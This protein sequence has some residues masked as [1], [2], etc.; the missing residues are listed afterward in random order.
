MGKMDNQAPFAPHIQT[1][2]YTILDTIFSLLIAILYTRII[3]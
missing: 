1:I 3:S 2:I